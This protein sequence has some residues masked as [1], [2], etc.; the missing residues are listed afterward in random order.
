MARLSREEQDT[1]IAGI[2]SGQTDPAKLDPVT[3]SLLLDLL[4]KILGMIFK[5]KTPAEKE[6]L[7]RLQGVM[8]TLRAQEKA[9]RKAKK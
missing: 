4:I 5:R 1:L 6:E 9:N 3:I 7:K 8:A 2:A